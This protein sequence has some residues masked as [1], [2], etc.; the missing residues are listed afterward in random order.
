MDRIIE[1]KVKGNHLTQD[2]NVAGLQYEGNVTFLR[3]EFDKGWDNYTK[4]VIFF[5]AYGQNPVKR[6][7]TADLLEDITES[8][9]IYLCGI[10]PEPLMHDG[11]MEYVIEGYHDGKRQRAIEAKLKVLPSPYAD[12][13][14]EPTDPTPS[15]A[16]QIQGQ[17]ENILSDMQAE[18]IRA[19]TAR[20]GAEEAQAA[21]EV[22]AGNAETAEYNAEEAQ[23]K[24]EQAAEDALDS[25]NVTEGYKTDAYSYMLASESAYNKAAVARA[26]AQEA[27]GKAETAQ[28]KAET[29]QANAEKAAKEA[30]EKATAEADE[31]LRQHI[32]DSTAARDRAETAATNAEESEQNA[33]QSAIDAAGSANAADQYAQSVN[34]DEIRSMIAS[35]GDGLYYDEATH[36]LYL[37]SG[38]EII[39]DGIQVAS[40]TGGGGGGGESNNAVLTLKNTTGWMYKSVSL[41]A[42]CPITFSWSSLEDEIPTGNGVLKVS[43]NGTVKDTTQITQGDHEIDVGDLLVAGTCTLKVNVTDTY[44]NS[45]SINFNITAVSLELSSTFDATI[46]YEGD[47]TFPYT[48]TA[49]VTKTM[50][51]AVDGKEV[52]EATV[53]ASGRQQTFT[54]PAQAHGMHI[55]EAWYDAV[56]DGE[57]VESDKLRYALI[58]KVQGNTTPIIATDWNKATVEQ[59]DT[60]NIPYIVYDPVSLSTKVSLSDGGTPTELTVDRTKQVWS[61]RVANEGAFTLS[62]ACGPTIV[63]LEM[64]ATPTSID[65][66]AETNDLSLYLTSYGRNNHEDT[67][68]EWKYGDVN[69]VLT[70]FNFTSD[71]WVND[72]DGITVLR[73]SGD[74][75]VE[76]PVQLFASDFRTTGKTIEIEFASRSVLDYDAIIATCWTGERGLKITAQQALLKS[77]KSEVATRYKE[78]DHLRLSF[79]I[80]KRSSHRL[81]IAYVNGIISGMIQYP[82]TDDFSQAV[83][84]SISLG[85]NDCT[86]DIYNIRVYEN[87]LTRF[88][89]LDNWIADTQNLLDKRDRFERNDIF[90]EYGVILPTTLKAHQCYLILRCPVLPQFKGDKKTCSGTYVD[91]VNPKNSFTFT[92]AEIDVQGT[93]SQYYYVKNF[94]IKFKGGFILWNGTS[95]T[96]YAMNENAVPTAE[97]T[98][99]ADVASSEGANNVVLAELYN[100]LCPVKTPAQERD[101]RVRQ[102]IEGHPIVVF[103]DSG[104]GPQF[105]G[106]YNFNNDKGTAEVF[107]FANGDESWE[108]LENGNALVSFKST[109]FTNWKTSFEARF[110]DK[111]TNITRLQQFVTWVASTD[112][113]VAG[114]TENEKAARLTKFKNEITDWADVDDAIF[115]YLFTLIFLCIDQREKNAFPTYNAEM[116]KWLWLF[117][118]ADSS[119]GTDNKGNLTF[120]YWMEDIDFTEAGDPVFNGQNNVF[121]TNLRLCFAD[122][123]KAEY[124]RL[125]TDIREDGRPLLSYEVVDQLF[126]AHQ[127]QWSE[128]IYNEDAWRKAVEPL[129]KDNDALYLPMQQGKKE[130]HFK[131]W[132]Y[133]R[134]RYL[135]SKFETGSAMSDRITMRAHAQGS[136]FLTSYINMY[137]QVYFNAAMDEHRMARDTETEF[138]WQAEGAEDAV[139]GVNNAAMLTSLGDLSPL[140]LELIDISGALHLTY[141][142]VGDGTE[143]YINDNLNS[144]TLGNNTLLRTLDVRNCTKLTQSVDASGC[145][146]IEE[147]YFDG[148]SVTGVSLP[149]GGNLK[150]LHLPATVTDLTLLNQTKLTEFVMPD[151]SK[152]TTLRI[153]NTPLVDT[154]AI[155]DAMA[156]GS[157]IRII[158]FDW[159]LNSAEA[160]MAFCNKLDT[161]RGLDE[162]GNNTDH[163]QMQGII[164]VDSIA[165]SQLAA[166]Q[167]RYPGIVIDYKH[168]SPEVYFYDENGSALLYSTFVPYGS[169]VTYSG[170]APTKASTAQYDYTFAGWT[171]VKGGSVEADALLNLTENRTLYACFTATVRSYTVYFYNGNTLLTSQSVQYG[172]AA[173]YAGTTPTKTST[174]QYDYTFNG[175]S[176]TNGGSADENALNNITSDRN[177]YA[178]FKADIRKYTVRFYVG[179][180]LVSSVA[181]AYGSTAVYTGGTPTKTATAQYN[182]SF[183]GW[184]K[185]ED[186]SVDTDALT[187]IVSDRDV[188]ACFTATVRSYTVRFYNGT[189]LIHT[190]N[191]TYG[192]NAVYGETTP[193]KAGNAQ[194]S[195]SFNGWSKTNDNSADND[196]LTN[197][198]GDRSVYACFTQTVNTYTV[199]FYNGTTLLQTISVAYGS[200]AVYGGSTP[201]KAATA[202]YSYSFAGWS[203]TNDNSTDNDALTG[204]I[205]NRDLYACFNAAVIYYT[206]SF[207]DGGTLLYSVA[208]PYGS[209]A[210]YGGASTDKDGYVFEGWSIADD[211]TADE[212]ALTNVTTNRTLYTCY[213]KR[214]PAGKVWAQS[215]ITRDVGGDAVNVGGLVIAGGDGGIYT[216]D[217]LQTWTK[218]STVKV[219]DIEVADGWVVAVGSGSA[220]KS[221]NGLQWT[222][223][224]QP[225]KSRKVYNADGVWLAGASYAGL[226]GIKYSLD[227]TTWSQSN[228]TSGMGLWFENANGIFVAGTSTGIYY[229]TDGQTW[230]QSNVTLQI[231]TVIVYAQQKWLCGGSKGLYAS[232]DGKTWEQLSGTKCYDVAYGN[233]MWVRV[234]MNRILEYSQDAETWTTIEGASIQ[235]CDFVR[236]VGLGFVAGDSAGLFYSKG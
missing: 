204:I 219:T 49:A 103:H 158:G 136:I 206:V 152:V 129:E 104:N 13:A 109:D 57:T 141:L 75:R 27:Q 174:T 220:G 96:V 3:I 122:D 59:F 26:E 16:E 126:E 84:V 25:K 234:L 78:D 40:G 100:E 193:T 67:P 221:Q 202:Q 20:T 32:A 212:N 82:D 231:E 160:L 56:I 148:S 88:Q 50:H 107:G 127:S 195:Y 34:P 55:F 201:T 30:A 205:T 10:P 172:L 198:T 200:N 196:A 14:G 151:Y 17:I 8:T 64:T 167:N 177:V 76:I 53:I 178:A 183:S 6:I 101:T 161:M 48:P 12:N 41:G 93:S 185:A 91:P 60:L 120:E 29:A 18:A 72:D 128:A 203:K 68:S 2:N 4:T 137:G 65:V 217:D 11:K 33:A 182:Y 190:V 38:G 138:V 186:N 146:N 170:V 145:T 47:I 181:A 149:K 42:S 44:G 164:R 153:E 23:A 173:D 54:I 71:G 180:S 194:Y 140:M 216:T 150:K 207:F 199:R 232:A 169:D 15:Q 1:V 80:E 123:I 125:R 69:A 191:V 113:T 105:I 116:S 218:R 7:L 46:A 43:V 87:D 142:K 106:K 144:L 224:S 222:T 227:G 92:N 114:L 63:L 188:Y 236:Y 192:G 66:K 51:F 143:G 19:E 77:E 156:A 230:T 162:N 121:W 179:S 108:I 229:S 233:G 168:I 130:Q 111:N 124:Q 157:R 39:S 94:K 24:A 70:G 35:R 22:A 79:A 58:C 45:R 9:R 62:I 197:I 74:A 61:Y 110:P 226:W 213:S 184:S 81:I 163:A 159:T 36:L 86:L 187:N 73:V 210:T 228:I 189:A 208:V 131:H 135:D 176:L 215:D 235:N 97:F 133:N 175:W 223:V 154:K 147:V 171:T 90:D 28:N 119:I 85:S 225:A 99:K 31:L 37:T 102:T 155:F 115:Y 214:E 98:F 21:A 5:D 209:S 112:T 165:I 95:A 211:G 89:V 132:M 134:F 83:P 117:Y 139:I 118:D 166:I 52:G